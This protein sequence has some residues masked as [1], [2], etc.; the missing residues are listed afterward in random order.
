[1]LHSEKILQ[2]NGLG[3]SVEPTEEEKLL[4]QQEAD[5]AE[6]AKKA[7]EEAARLKEEAELDVPN[8]KLIEMLKK[9]GIE[10]ESIE[11]LK[12]K[13]TEEEE[14]N[15]RK[16]AKAKA[17][18]YA[19]DTN[20]FTQEEYDS[21]AVDSKKEKIEIAR[22]EFHKKFKA[23]LGENSEDEYTD[24][25]IDLVFNREFLVDDT[26]DSPIK[27]IKQKEID[28]LAENFLNKK[29]G[30]ILNHEAVF[31]DYNSNLSKAKT[32]KATIDEEIE[33]IKQNSLEFKIGDSKVTYKPTEETFAKVSEL[34]SSPEM[35]SK[36][37]AESKEVLQN[38]I[39]SSLTQMDFSKIV[40]EIA[41]NYHATELKKINLGRQGIIER[42]GSGQQ[43]GATG[44]SA[45]PHADGI[46]NS[47]KKK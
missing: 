41:E 15:N 14:E 18:K 33:L 8:E 20:I 29:Y 9:K 11:A 19:V 31:N 12:P 4:A 34:Y 32:Y 42:N 16:E 7:E 36:I 44:A 25:D 23:A 39:M 22:S 46:V 26:E 24:E 43:G 30:K 28:S 37:G 35:Y 21:F 3:K 27:K 10:I 38:A 17:F 2:E 13:P 1:M 5:A 45:T 47:N 6:A 40:S